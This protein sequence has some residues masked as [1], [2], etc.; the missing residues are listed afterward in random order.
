MD[1]VATAE[2]EYFEIQR[3]C[4]SIPNSQVREGIDTD[5]VL[6]YV[7]EIAVVPWDLDH[8]P[9]HHIHS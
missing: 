7:P 3:P 6:D 9:L 8:D 4:E 1:L 2:L 5:F